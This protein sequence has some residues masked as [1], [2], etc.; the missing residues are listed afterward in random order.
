MRSIG[1]Y[2]A[3]GVE[4][5]EI[6]DLVNFFGKS[7]FEIG[8]GRGRMTMLFAAAASHVL[9]FDPDEESIAAAHEL[10]PEEVEDKVEYRVAGLLD[11]KLPENA[12]DVG[13]FAWSI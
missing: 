7:V 8:C 3:E 1:T 6:H 4:K 11:V 13:V 10:T 5:R 2:D 12:F 9:A